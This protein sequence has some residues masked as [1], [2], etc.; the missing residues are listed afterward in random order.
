ML[1]LLKIFG[2]LLLMKVE[3]TNAHPLVAGHCDAGGDLGLKSV[4]L[5]GSG[6]G[7]SL[8]LGGITAS[9]DGISLDTL[10]TRT[11][12]S[13]T[14]YTLKLETKFDFKGFLIRLSDRSGQTVK[15]TLGLKSGF[16]SISQEL[17]QCSS[18]VDGICHVNRLVKTSVEVEFLYDKKTSADLQLDITVVKNNNAQNR[19]D[20]FFSRYE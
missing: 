6:G 3:I 2:L 19:N 17:D 13:D 11:L 20:W 18:L 15:G 4:G 5:H 1:P 7:D 9:I 16:E 10:N 14:P 12:T 8:F